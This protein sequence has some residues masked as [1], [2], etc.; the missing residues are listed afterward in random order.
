MHRNF[1]RQS[2]AH[3]STKNRMLLYL[4]IAGKLLDRHIHTSLYV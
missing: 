4:L 1:V 3:Y 2:I